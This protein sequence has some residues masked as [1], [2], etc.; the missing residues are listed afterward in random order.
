MRKIVV[1]KTVRSVLSKVI[2]KSRKLVKKVNPLH[3]TINLNNAILVTL[4]VGIFCARPTEWKGKLPRQWLKMRSSI[5]FIIQ[6]MN[7]KVSLKNAT[8]RY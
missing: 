4:M 8:E 3:Q 7:P 5:A 6:G 1:S 2:Q